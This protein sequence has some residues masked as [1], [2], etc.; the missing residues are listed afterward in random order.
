[1]AFSMAPTP[2]WPVF[3]AVGEW[4]TFS[5]TAAFAAYAGG[6]ALSLFLAGHLSDQYGRRPLL[7]IGLAME[8]AS[9]GVILFSSNL[10]PVIVARVLGGI[11]VGLITATATAHIVDLAGPA[12]GVPIAGLANLGGF[13]LG[14]VVSGAVADTADP[15]RAP[16][17]AFGVALLIAVVLVRLTAETVALP[18]TPGIY[19]PQRIR[20]PRES[21]GTFRSVTFVTAAAF[22]MLGLFSSLV[23]ALVAD[24]SGSASHL[25]AGL[26][27]FVVFFSS[28][29]AQVAL[30]RTTIT[31]RLSV[32]TAV[33]VVG[34]LLVVLGV[35]NR[36]LGVLVAGGVVAGFGGGLVTSGALATATT[37]AAP[38]RRSELT[39]GVFLAGYAGL[40]LPIVVVGVIIEAVGVQTSVIVFA[41][42]IVS[43][44]GAAALARR[45]RATP[46]VATVSEPSSGLYRAAT[47]RYDL[48]AAV[49]PRFATTVTSVSQLRAALANAREQNL[50]VRVHSTGH[51]ASASLP[52]PEDLLI[53]ID[54]HE[55]VTVD[56]TAQTVRIPAGHRWGDVV[57]ELA[58][59]GL[60]VPHGSSPDVG[61]IGYL[62]RGG[63]S[64]YGRSVGVAANSVESIE[65]VTASGEILEAS[66]AKNGELF[67]ALRG[68]GGGFGIVT[69]ITVRAFP[70]HEVIT[71]TAIW[72]AT[73]AHQLGEAWESWTRTA[74]ACAS[75]SFRIM[76]LPPLPGVPA[77]IAGKPIVVIDGAVVAHDE[78]QV[79]SARNAAHDL[80]APL[81]A[82]STPLLDTWRAG[83]ILDVPVTHM[84][85]PVPL[86]HSADHMILRTLGEGGIDTFIDAALGRADDTPLA[87]VELRQLGGAFD[88]APATAG[89]VGRL[90]GDF[91]MLAVGMHSRKHSRSAIAAR[92]AALRAE[93][94][95]WD[96]GFTA[97]TWV[98]TP[99]Q[100]QR[101]FDA[102]TAERVA[103]VRSVVDPTGM[104][105]GDVQRAALVRELV[106]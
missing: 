16:F 70:V 46:G 48:A 10:A 53:R 58:G 38:H 105:A 92:L 65:L 29:A 44:L 69:A 39:A 34:L 62:L 12:R 100:P 5:V 52:M 26:V 23:P 89:A 56:A 87:A 7:T 96:T 37:L 76:S 91:A 98:A 47:R 99:D 94:E 78:T 55:P 93:L 6:V 106:R 19:Q 13:A 9:V 3:Q 102:A 31:L 17:L 73:D 95:P 81:R 59:H 22:G 14:P 74:S 90:D 35:F 32:G 104:F 50:T 64:F 86:R 20:V 21:L 57:G 88:T 43:A 4:S 40:A 66:S 67:W 30:S 61:A 27:A 82:V 80:L 36:S 25:L 84:D 71:G 15:L 60:S 41:C 51:A 79:V 103:R 77:R 101:S 8:L 68:G 72:A 85:P 97:P 49:S 28:A 42:I 11:G 33:L 45:K 24:I 83:S 63:M 75:T 18:R 2:L 54:L 1:M